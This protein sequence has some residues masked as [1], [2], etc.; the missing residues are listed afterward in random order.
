[1][2]CFPRIFFSSGR[3]YYLFNELLSHLPQKHH[4]T[5]YTIFQGIKV[6]F[7]SN[8]TLFLLQVNYFIED[9]N[10]K[11]VNAFVVPCLK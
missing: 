4:K 3:R 1:M 6:S 9:H 2:L 7:E 8:K 5:Y 10:P 11:P